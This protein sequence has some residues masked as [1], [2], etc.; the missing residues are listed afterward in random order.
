MNCKTSLIQIAKTRDLV[1]LTFYE[2]IVC[3]L[4]S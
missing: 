1:L 2:N 4:Y 3:I